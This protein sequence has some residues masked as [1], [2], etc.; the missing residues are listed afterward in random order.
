MESYPSSDFVESF[1]SIVFVRELP[2]LL[3]VNGVL[4]S[5]DFVRELPIPRLRPRSSFLRL[6]HRVPRPSLV[7]GVLPLVFMNGAYPSSS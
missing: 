4:P 3:F 7:N 1:P 2:C 6:R 5:S